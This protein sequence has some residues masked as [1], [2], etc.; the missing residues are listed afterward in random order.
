[1]PDPSVSEFEVAVG[2]LKWCKSAVLDQII[3]ELIQA[4]EETLRSEIYKLKLIWNK[5]ELPH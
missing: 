1:V 3:A 5:E 2:K 4:G